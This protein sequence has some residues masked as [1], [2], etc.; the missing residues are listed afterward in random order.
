MKEMKLLKGILKNKSKVTLATLI[1]FLIT[2]NIS[3][4]SIGIIN[5]NN[6]DIKNIEATLDNTLFISKDKK[7]EGEIE[8][9][10]V[11]PATE[12]LNIINNGTI[13]S[14]GSKNGIFF[15]TRIPGGGHIP[16]RNIVLDKI[17]NNGLILT[18]KTGI[19]HTKPQS[20][21][22]IFIYNSEYSLTLDSLSN[23]GTIAGN[24]ETTTLDN[25]SSGNGVV[26]KGTTGVMKNFYN[27]GIIK[28]E[29]I[30]N[31]TKGFVGNGVY[32]NLTSIDS[33]NNTGTI[34][35]KATY[36]S[37]KG[38][39]GNTGN[40]MHL[41]VKIDNF[42]NSGVISGYVEHATS[43]SG[44]GVLDIYTD[45]QIT[46]FVNSGVI[47][48]ETGTEDRSSHEI[49]DYAMGAYI[50]MGA[51]DRKSIV[52]NLGVIAGY[53]LNTSTGGWGG[54]GLKILVDRNQE[55]IVNNKGIL[56]G[57]EGA[58]NFVNSRNNANSG[59]GL[60]IEQ[61]IGTV[62]VNNNGTIAGYNTIGE[63][64]VLG[65][66]SFYWKP[67]G[68]FVRASSLLESL[69]SKI[70][71]QGVIK[72]NISAITI[73]PTNSSI[74]SITNNGI[75]A[76]KYI[77]SIGTAD[78]PTTSSNTTLTN[79]GSFVYI[80]TINDS[81]EKI[82]NGIG[83]VVTL[84]DGT[85]RTVVNGT[86]TGSVSTGPQTI[87]GSD[88]YVNASNLIS[89]DN[90]I[91]NGAGVNKG[92]LVI[93]KD[94]TLTASV[95][96]GYS[97][98]VYLESEKT[99]T[100]TNTTFNGGGL[101]NDIAVIKG[102]LGNNTASILGE[103][104]INGGVD[105][106][107][108]DDV[109]S[110]SNTVQINGKMDGGSGTGDILNLGKLSNVE[111]SPNLNIF[112]DISG[113][114]NINTNGNIT[115]FETAKV[116]GASNIILESGDLTL[117]VDPTEKDAAGK[118]TGH[119]LYG[120]SGI[121]S[122]TEGNLVVGLNGLGENA[123]VSMGG[124]TIIAGTNGNWWDDSDHIKTNSLVLDG[125]LSSDG[126]D[127]NITV[128]EWIPT[129]PSTPI[130]PE[131]PTDSDLTNKIDSVLYEKLN[132]VY[133]SIVTAGEIGNLANTTGLDDKT[134]NQSLGGLLV[135]LDQIYTNNPYSYTLKSS[136]DSLKLFED[137]MLY[138]TI[139]PKQEE[140]I[141]QG[142]GIYTG[143][144]NDNDS[145]GKNYYGFDTGHRNYDTKTS[146]SGGIATLEYGVSDKIS[147]GLVIGGNT[148]KTTFKGLSKIDGNSMYLG[149]FAKA[150]VSNYRFM[151]G[152]GYQ[153]TSSAVERGVSNQYDSFKTE[154][155]YDINSYNAFIEV[156]YVIKGRENWTLEPKTRLSYY[157]VEQDKVNEGY[158]PGQLSLEVDGSTSSTADIEI[159]ID[160]V[161][162]IQLEK[163]KLN[164]VFSFGVINTLGST[165]K[166]LQGRVLGNNKKGT[167]FGIQGVELPRTSGKV[168]YNLELEQNN[169][170][171]YTTGISLEFSKDYNR[172][173]SATVGIGYKF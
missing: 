124:T 21:N 15:D 102:D 28:G 78:Y 11:N 172:N 160:L 80:D 57:Y 19:S 5:Q 18:D 161:K 56:L 147:T 30:Q 67:A 26:L 156:K 8:L 114:E 123:V 64:N 118:I 108:G 120:N 83:G 36:S 59:V 133:H 32:L 130:E 23:N 2:G 154:D 77:L 47:T 119:A 71:N 122:S 24:Y 42:N 101:K 50:K 151:G 149:A 171:I 162:K 45:K 63:N 145:S 135:A 146:T 55:Q 92:A 95:I 66:S 116:T 12:G 85:T 34:S 87:I 140:W 74:S 169:G 65:V 131:P 170:M 141:A 35:G 89:L 157:Y 49:N 27:A 168:S 25:S 20:G 81:V 173:V 152:L 60:F 106:G 143:I 99:L 139:K 10:L 98:A 51:E 150:E 91:I 167:N 62:K 88:S 117:R 155:K 144:K 37:V 112:H 43:Y 158:V 104:V 48:G 31:V 17:L 84:E 79:N 61:E 3:L 125:K 54:Q 22:G 41:D 1:I 105:L 138:L 109:L 136:R 126:K 127:I 73:S 121:L 113:F 46:S 33:I 148:Q 107:A 70:Y 93:D 29:S 90:V 38:T 132:K 129:G 164:N 115:L 4:G 94:I 111:A 44:I 165:Q 58:N 137:N 9:N 76:G 13:S 128:K 68:L 14:T 7:I 52:E 163:I 82:E 39:T 69:N 153:Y 134:F 100:A 86:T 159:G 72:S 97:T 166:E 103:S 16:S 53:Q 75:L 110:I 142:K 6:G 96:N 40:G